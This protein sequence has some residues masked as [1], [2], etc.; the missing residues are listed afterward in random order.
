MAISIFATWLIVCL[1]FSPD[2]VGTLAVAASLANHAARLSFEVFPF[3]TV[4]GL[5]A[6]RAPKSPQDLVSNGPFFAFE[7]H[8]FAD[9][10]HGFT[11]FALL[12]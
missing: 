9:Y 4:E 3:T 11:S 8:S 7:I 2:F 12:R 10:A 5:E 6:F 1:L